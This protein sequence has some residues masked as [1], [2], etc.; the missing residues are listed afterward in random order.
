MKQTC[1]VIEIY[2]MILIRITA[3]L[4]GLKSHVTAR[5]PLPA[6]IA[7]S[8]HINNST[9]NRIKRMRMKLGGGPYE[10]IEK[11]ETFISEIFKILGYDLTFLTYKLPNFGGV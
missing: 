1:W 6:N 2:I 3:T 9:I 8:H 10:N 5:H 7:D 11:I 4:L